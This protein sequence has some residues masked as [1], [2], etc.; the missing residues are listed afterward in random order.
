[1]GK[2]PPLKFT[3]FPEQTFVLMRHHVGLHL[4]HEIHGHNHDNEQ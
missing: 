2:L 4:L 1:V 3:F